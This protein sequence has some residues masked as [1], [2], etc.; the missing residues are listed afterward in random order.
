MLSRERERE[1]R[2]HTF[3]YIRK[4]GAGSV[5]ASPSPKGGLRCKGGDSRG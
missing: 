5:N 3:D 2:E 4:G 1:S